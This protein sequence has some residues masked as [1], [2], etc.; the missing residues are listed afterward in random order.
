MV[1]HK[2]YWWWSGPQGQPSPAPQKKREVGR[3]VE[4]NH[5]GGRWGARWQIYED[6]YHSQIRVRSSVDV[7]KR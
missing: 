7:E 6:D 3:E 1:D 5:R 4:K 2:D